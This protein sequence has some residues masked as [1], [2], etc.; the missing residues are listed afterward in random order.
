M[1]HKA[2]DPGDLGAAEL[3]HEPLLGATL[4]TPRQPVVRVT[5]VK[6]TLS[7]YWVALP[8]RY[9]STT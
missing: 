9:S 8:E 1:E 3:I 6:Q 5:V 2:G 4:H 7:K